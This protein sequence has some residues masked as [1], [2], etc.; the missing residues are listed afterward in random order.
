[1]TC[2]QCGAP[3]QGALCRG[4]EQI[5]LNEKLHGTEA[6]EEYERW[7]LE[8]AAEEADDAE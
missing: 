2:S 1:M 3:C 6:A 7:E 5:E 8:K 4:C